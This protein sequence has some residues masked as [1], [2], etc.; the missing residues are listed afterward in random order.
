[1]KFVLPGA[2]GGETARKR[3]LAEARSAA[4]L[5]HPFICKV[6]ETGEVDGRPFIVMEYVEGEGLN[7]RLLSGTPPLKET[8]RIAVEIA[9]ALATAHTRGIVHRD[10]KPSNIMLTQDGHVKVMDFGL[11]KYVSAGSIGTEKT[12]TMTLTEAGVIPGT[13]IFMSP[14]QLKD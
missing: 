9:E 11:A 5:D 13:L 14:E 3:L 4:A 6:Y 12:A 7:D 10:L 8:L 1:L 2:Q